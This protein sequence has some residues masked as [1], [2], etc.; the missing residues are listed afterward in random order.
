MRSE[1][2]P[3]ETVENVLTKLC[4]PVGSKAFCTLLPVK[5]G[6]G[7]WGGYKQR[8]REEVPEQ[9]PSDGCSNYPL[10]GGLFTNLS[11]Q[12]IK[13]DKI[14]G[15]VLQLKFPEII[16]VG[17]EYLIPLAVKEKLPSYHQLQQLFLKCVLDEQQA[18]SCFRTSYRNVLPQWA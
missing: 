12:L 14:Q 7:W 10:G 13:P 17:A 2:S 18:P 1:G 3:W 11:C 4:G 5:E 16:R 9:C 6:G 8:T 15:P